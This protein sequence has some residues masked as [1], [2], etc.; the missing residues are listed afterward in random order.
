MWTLQ[1]PS[2][3]ADG[4]A[5]WDALDGAPGTKATTAEAFH[6]EVLLAARESLTSTCLRSE[7]EAIFASS[8]YSGSGGMRPHANLA[9]YS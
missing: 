6:I 8:R 4:S 1:K 5:C 7:A 2:E 3:H 9:S